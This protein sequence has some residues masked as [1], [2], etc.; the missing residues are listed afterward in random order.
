MM[1]SQDA[2]RLAALA[3]LPALLY[4]A[5]LLTLQVHFAHLFDLLAHTYDRSLTFN[6]M[7]LHLLRGSFDVDPRTI[8]TEG[9]VRGDRTY[10]YFGIFPALF[11]LPFLA[12]PDFETTDF[13]RLSCL[14][15]DG[16]MASFKLS[17]VIL[18][19]RAADNRGQMVLLYF[20][21]GATILLGGA[22]IQFLKPSIYN[23]S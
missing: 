2:A 3:L 7:L 1:R 21:L 4:Y 20:A 17:S 18:I 11:R 23:E 6:S 13:T 12:W 10:A 14:V 9:F 22:Q 19:W 5:F 16:V 8:G 15:A